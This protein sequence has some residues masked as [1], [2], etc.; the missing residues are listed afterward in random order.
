[1]SPARGQRERKTRSAR[2][3]GRGERTRARLLEVAE[4]LFARHGYSGTSLDAIAARAGMHKPGIC[5]YFPSKRALYEA[6]LGEVLGSFEGLADRALSSPGSA[7]QRLLRSVETWVD[8][9][10]ARPTAARLI[11]HEIANPDP[12]GVPGAFR[13]PG[14]R[15]YGLIEGAF[16]ELFPDAHPD[17]AFLFEST[18]AGATLFFA[19][20][21]PQRL[22]GGGE[23]ELPHSLERHKTMLMRTAR[24]LLRELRPAR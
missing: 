4:A 17:D 1:V 16:H 22:S 15:A 24:G 12:T 2:P 18:I 9:L 13:G 23:S 6:V 21:M 3:Q 11:L 14:A 20:G 8:A 5:Y 19:T 7:R 10:A